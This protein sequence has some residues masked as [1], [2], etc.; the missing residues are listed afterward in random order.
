MQIVHTPVIRHR[1][2]RYPYLTVPGM[3]GVLGV[4][5]QRTWAIVRENEIETLRAASNRVYLEPDNVRAMLELRGFAFPRK[6]FSFQLVKG[7]TGKTTLAFSFIVRAAHYGA[8]VLAVDLDKQG[9]LTLALGVEADEAEK[10]PTW[11]DIH[12]EKCG[13][14][15]VIV[16]SPAGIDLM[17]A[18][19]ALGDL[20][21]V[22]SS[23]KQS[24]RDF[25]TDALAPVRD[26]YDI[27]VIDCAPDTNKVTKAATCASSMVIM[28]LDADAFAA[29]GLDIAL[30]ELKM[31]S[32]RYRVQ[33]DFQI[34]WTKLDKRSTL[35]FDLVLRVANEPRCAGKVRKDPIHTD[36][37]YGNAIRAGGDGRL[38]SVFDYPRASI[39]SRY[40]ID[41]LTRDLLG[42]NSWHSQNR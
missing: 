42:M 13:A 33:P 8:R 37:S 38:R 7:G 4:G 28:P 39:D 36:T 10:L 26:R 23:G 6:T 32:E 16:K 17:P 24:I 34:V 1:N 9:D 20:N 2:P 40:D 22:M 31:V 41:L 5:I 3:A 29:K 12:A 14:A 27:V 15:D 19:L 30:R 35:G 21:D 25:V 18:N 11:L